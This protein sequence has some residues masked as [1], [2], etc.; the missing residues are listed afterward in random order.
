[1]EER[2]VFRTL[3]ATGRRAAQVDALQQDL[4]VVGRIPAINQDPG[5]PIVDHIDQA[6]HLR[7]RTPQTGD[8]HATNIRASRLTRQAEKVTTPSVRRT[9][10]AYAIKRLCVDRL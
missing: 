10:I 4:G 7:M 3:L 6:A 2:P 1:M 8:F 5:D 9:P